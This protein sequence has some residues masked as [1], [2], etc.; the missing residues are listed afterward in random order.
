M[1]MM[2]TGFFHADP[3]PGNLMRTDDGKL[4]ILDFGLVSK[5][6]EA[7]QIGIFKNMA[8]VL[9]QNYAGV[10][11]TYYDLGFIPEDNPGP[12]VYESVFSEVFAG[13]LDRNPG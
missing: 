13:L 12:E 7:E 10:V 3:H 6:K 11:Q 4:C 9:K 8:Y 2:E 1:Q 5:I